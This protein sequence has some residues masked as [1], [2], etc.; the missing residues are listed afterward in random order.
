MCKE[1][2]DWWKKELESSENKET[3]RGYWKAEGTRVY[4]KV[5]R[6]KRLVED[7]EVTGCRVQ[8]SE[9]ILEDEEGQEIG[10]KY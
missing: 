5:Y 7:L 1:P 3:N 10:E 9:M 6:D 8:K 4:W 2:K